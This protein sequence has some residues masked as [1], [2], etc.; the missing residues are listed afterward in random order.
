MTDGVA[1]STWNLILTDCYNA[2]IEVTITLKSGKEFS[3]YVQKH[4]TK[5]L[6]NVIQIGDRYGRVVF[7][8]DVTEIAT[9]TELR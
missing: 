9:I 1:S 5:F 4:P 7:S 3:G 2:S 8:I 6:H